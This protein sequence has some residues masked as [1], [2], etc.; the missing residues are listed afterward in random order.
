MAS[1]VLKVATAHMIVVLGSSGA[2]AIAFA[3]SIIL[4]RVLGA[5][6]FGQL[7]LFTATMLI[8]WQVPPAFDT[9]FIRY[10]KATDSKDDIIDSLRAATRLKLLFAGLAI[11][12]AFPISALVNNFSGEV[13]HNGNLVAAGIICGSMLSFVSSL[14]NIMRVREQFAKYS[15]VQGVYNLAIFLVVVFMAYVLQAASIQN[16]LFIYMAM[17]LAFGGGSLGIVI[18][19]SGNPFKST[20]KAKKNIFS[21]GKWVFL[22]TVAFHFASRIDILTLPYFIEYTQVGIYAAALQLL[23]I[24]NTLNSSMSAVFMP[25]AILAIKSRENMTNYF[26]ESAIPICLV[27]CA[28]IVLYIIA[29]FCFGLFFPPEY[30]PAT[31]IF[32]ILLIGQLFQTVYL[33]FTYLYYAIDKLGIRCALEYSKLALMLALLVV[34]I[35]LRGMPG[36]A[37]AMSA[38]IAIN[39]IMCIGLFVVLFR[40]L[41]TFTAKRD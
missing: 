16:V 22:V 11:L 39:C 29:P 23:L 20:D 36:A 27:L 6:S 24:I 35:P 5:E 32:R 13:A 28:I 19:F 26:K 15:L 17:A 33:P 1:S 41:N 34:F 25:R 30:A 18:K 4:A 12:S 7:S 8:T 21:F 14:A 10:A 40:G 3:T 38:A 9:A 31:N 2:K 37:E